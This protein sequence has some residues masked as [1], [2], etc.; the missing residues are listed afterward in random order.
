M[1]IAPDATGYSRLA[2]GEQAN[3]LLHD[4]L[5][6][7]RF[8][9]YW[10]YLEPR[11]KGVEL[12]DALLV[13]DNTALLFEVKARG[14][15]KPASEAWLRKRLSKAVNQLNDRAAMLHRGG[16]VLRNAWRGETVFDPNCIQHLYGVVV[17]AAGFEPFEWR[18]LASA[19]FR[20]TQIPVQVY[21][22]FDLAEL[23]RVFNTPHDLL[24]Y[25]E[26]RAEYG[27][28][29]RML[30]GGE[31]QTFQE[32]VSSWDRLWGGDHEEGRK[33]QNYLL[34][35]GNAVFRTSLAGDAGYR[36]WAASLLIDFAFR[37]ADWRADEDP[38]GRRVGGCRHENLVKG[39]EALAELS[40][41]RRSFY[42]EQW[43][44]VTDKAIAEGG[45]ATRYCHSPSRSRS[46][47]LVATPP[48][49]E[50]AQEMLTALAL[51][52]MSEHG[53]T[54]SIALAAPASAI[55][56]T[57][58]VLLHW[59]Q[60]EEAELPDDQLILAPTVAWVASDQSDL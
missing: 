5:L 53:T 1:R 25:Y 54:S 28:N 52:A 38:S 42:G 27:R 39:L 4:V 6:R 17:L 2:P 19:A 45:V 58:E 10:T 33:M 55:R 56:A 46:Y 21:S 15:P 14:V 7:P 26:L 31:L 41:N 3:R 49:E 37:P 11:H 40:R 36:A 8:L 30:V 35:L 50:P 51:E 34:D 32:V 13:W 9:G 18:E 23:L 59:C 60:A 43:L 24:L 48:G 44:G 29:Q 57:F 16:V 20:R 47:V 22:L 12:A